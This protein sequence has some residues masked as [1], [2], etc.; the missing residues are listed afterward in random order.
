MGDQETSVILNAKKTTCLYCSE[1]F[2]S[3][4]A[5]RHY[6][7]LR[8][9]KNYRLPKRNSFIHLVKEHWLNRDGNYVKNI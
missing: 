2:L 8:H 9:K 7:L 5:N 3:K 4:S 1:S 6:D